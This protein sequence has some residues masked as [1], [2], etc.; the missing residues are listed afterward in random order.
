MTPPSWIAGRSA[1]A[2][3][4]GLAVGLALAGCARP[5]ATSPPGGSTSEG[6]CEEAVTSVV[7]ATAAPGDVVTVSV[8]L[9][10]ADTG[11]PAQEVPIDV[12]V[13]WEQGEAVA[14]LGT[15]RTD[16]TGAVAVDVAV[17]DDAVPGPATLTAGPSRPATVTVGEARG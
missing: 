17:P 13:V 4:G 1:R 11:G 15:G 14:V 16:T 10:C 7:P 9:G 6:A 5:P 12:D 2:V 3:V 8:A